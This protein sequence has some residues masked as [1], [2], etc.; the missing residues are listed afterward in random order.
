MSG[1]T[2]SATLSLYTRVDWPATT[3]ADTTPIELVEIELK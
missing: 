3:A 2:P 1:S